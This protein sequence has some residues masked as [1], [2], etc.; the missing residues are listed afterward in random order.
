MSSEQPLHHSFFAHVG[1]I[2]LL[3]PMLVVFCIS[4]GH[5]K[6]SRRRAEPAVI[7]LHA[8]YGVVVP[9]QPLR[10]AV[11]IALGKGWYTYWY[12]PGDAGLAPELSW[13][14]PEGWRHSAVELPVPERFESMGVVSFGF[15]N[16]PVFL[17]TLTPPEQ[18][19]TD[20][21][22]IGLGIRLLLC[23]EECIP[24]V[25]TLKVSIPVTASVR[26]DSEG[27][28]SRRIFADAARRIPRNDT[29]SGRWRHADNNRIVLEIPLTDDAIRPENVSFF[30]VQRGIFDYHGSQEIT[31]ELSTIKL[32]L[33]L[34]RMREEVP[35][36]L[37][38][39][40]VTETGANNDITTAVYVAVKKEE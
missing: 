34:A 40:L 10:I 11:E 31:R 15:A 14:L 33:A 7:R 2:A 27:G 16:T 35:D 5:D 21:V 36:I 20:T 4:C 6:P 26:K 23:K 8:E 22:T 13:Q 25:D 39:L 32:S 29:L 37:T 18:V 12:N 28:S 38:G 9:G 3:A 1:P 24:F 17:A 19:P 30:P